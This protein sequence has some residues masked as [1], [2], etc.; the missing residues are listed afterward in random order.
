MRPWPLL[1]LIAALMIALTGAVRNEEACEHGATPV[2]CHPDETAAPVA[3]V[4]LRAACQMTAHSDD[5]HV[6]CGLCEK[7]FR[8]VAR[9]LPPTPDGVAGRLPQRTSFEPVRSRT[10][11]RHVSVVVS[12]LALRFSASPP[13]RA[14][15]A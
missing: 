10:I 8:P 14:P 4:T 11:R 6:G 12:A 7:P 9:F 5:L 3:N 13:L 15:P 2:C 1:I